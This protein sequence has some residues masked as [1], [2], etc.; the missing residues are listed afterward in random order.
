MNRKQIIIDVRRYLEFSYDS[1][2]PSLERELL[3]KGY[4]HSQLEIIRQAKECL[5]EWWNF[6][7]EYDID[8]IN[9]EVNI[10]VEKTTEKVIGKVSVPSTPAV[11][12]ASVSSIAPAVKPAVDVTK[13]PATKP[14]KVTPKPAVKPAP[15]PSEQSVKCELEAIQPATQPATKVEAPATKRVPFVG[16][17]K[18]KLL[19]GTSSSSIGKFIVNKL[20]GSPE[21]TCDQLA[22][23]IVNEFRTKTGIQPDLKWA[24]RNIKLFIEKGLIKAE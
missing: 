8:S 18:V 16:E 1:E 14:A 22:D 6:T 24:V 4:T 13:K 17:A 3:A 2:I 11:K 19:A 20:N 9:N 5:D 15:V 12:P 10:M 21:I 7:S 23:A